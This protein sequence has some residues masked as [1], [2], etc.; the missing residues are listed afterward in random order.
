MP[1]K[2]DDIR[3]QVRGAKTEKQVS[4]AADTTDTDNNALL[5]KI[6]SGEAFDIAEVVATLQGVAL[7][8]SMSAEGIRELNTKLR[9]A[10]EFYTSGLFEIFADNMRYF[11]TVID[12]KTVTFGSDGAVVAGPE[13]DL[14][15]G[16]PLETAATSFALVAG[17]HT[18]LADNLKKAQELEVEYRKRLRDIIKEAAVLRKVSS[19]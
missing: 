3:A 16:N 9:E 7:K 4:D 2:F 19:A 12:D 1:R 5:Q 6:S 11:D 18:M 15:G 13:L 14:E 10:N 17:H 8:Q